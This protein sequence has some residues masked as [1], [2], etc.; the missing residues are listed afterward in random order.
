[1]TKRRVSRRKVAAGLKA[2]TALRVRWEIG[3][4]VLAD[5]QREFSHDSVS[6]WNVASTYIGFTLGLEA[7]EKA[8]GLKRATPRETLY[9]MVYKPGATREDDT[10]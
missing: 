7:A 3:P 4:N 5:F 2:V 1:V 10:G 8:L 6:G 9:R